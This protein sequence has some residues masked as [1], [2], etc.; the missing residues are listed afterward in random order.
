MDSVYLQSQGLREQTPSGKPSRPNLLVVR[1]HR[2][3][4]GGSAGV[5]PERTD[6]LLHTRAVS[7]VRLQIVGFAGLSAFVVAV[8]A[9]H[10]I[11]ASLNPAEH[12]I[13]EYSLGSYGWLMRAAF[14]ALGVGT[15]ATAAILHLR[16]GPP[17]VWR[18]VA[19]L[20]LAGAA[21]GAFLVAGFNTDY[22]RVPETAHGTVHGVGTAIF[23]LALPGAAFVIGS[24]FFRSPS[25]A[26]EAR[27]LLI[28]GAAQ[29]GAIVFFEQSPTSVRGWAERL[30]S[31]LAIATLGL[32]QVILRTGERAGPPRTV[33]PQAPSGDRSS[34][35][36][37]SRQTTKL[38]VQFTAGRPQSGDGNSDESAG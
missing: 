23:V 12:T 17:G 36:R 4:R 18:P 35:F 19:A 24:E 13:S 33:D 11:Q 28:L 38:Q 25:L 5:A 2:L 1:P 22:L 32:I 9:L 10:G 3:R 14:V 16:G 31:V 30:V 6:R 21:I 7:L 20:T 27:V 29:L 34:V 8:L 15:L 26:P 37:R